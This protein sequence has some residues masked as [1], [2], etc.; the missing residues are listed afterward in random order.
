LSFNFTIVKA[1]ECS[2]EDKARL[3]RDAKEVK[4]I[5]NEKQVLLDPS[6]YY[7]TE[8]V[9]SPVYKTY[10]EMNLTNLTEEMYVEVE[11][12]FNKIVITNKDTN[13]EKGIIFENGIL[14]FN[15][16][17]VDRIVKFHYTI[18]ATSSSCAGEKLSEGY[19]T[20]PKYNY[21]SEAGICKGIEDYKYCS[22][23]IQE[24]IDYGDQF[25][26]ISRYK[27]SLEEEEAKKAKSWTEKAKRFIKEHKVLVIVGA[28]IIVVGGGSTVILKHRKKRVL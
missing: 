27:E 3:K 14:K 20:T 26:N 5:L 21:L 11:N 10:F 18:Y 12:D 9:D 22:R 16:E 2:L 6:T 25:D 7:N 1:A 4:M 15:W 19:Y 8:G 28:S 17:D 23:F 13:F 24:D